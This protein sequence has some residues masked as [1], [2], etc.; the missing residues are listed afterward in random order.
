MAFTLVGVWITLRAAPWRRAV[1]R[2]P[3]EDAGVLTL[4]AI[5]LGFL[6]L[7]LLSRRFVEF[8]APFSALFAGTALA[9]WQPGPA[10]G[11]RG[12][13]PAPVA[14]GA[15]VLAAVGWHNLTQARRIVGD[16]RGMIHRGCAVWIRDHVPAGATVF[17]TDWDEFPQL[18]LH[19]PLQRY[20]VG[21]DPTFM[22]VTDPARWR[23]WRE[24]AE[25]RA[26]SVRREV[27]D[28][29][30]ARHA[31]ADAWYG[32]FMERAEQEPGV[33]VAYADPECRVYEMEPTP[34]PRI[35]APQ[36]VTSWRVEGGGELRVAP[37][38]FVDLSRAEPKPAG[39]CARVDGTLPALPAARARIRLHT[40]DAIQVRVG[41]ALV[42]DTQ[43][44]RPPDYNDLSL[45][46][47]REGEVW[48]F[49]L[50]IA[51]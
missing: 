42:Y 12:W 14:A 3:A 48:G 20:L 50:E 37:G 29:F 39:R 44:P 5:T 51:P 17:T 9:A 27:V 16:D 31:F 7:S 43:A 45:T 6:G 28:T 38:D 13:R 35:P 32:P 23:A 18:F 8:W 2:R 22:Y 25:A 40:D 47:C 1:R 36:A 46:V 10:P 33:R 34:D 11:R 4:G 15:I 24:V 26:G 30:G 19:A 21:L 49:H 41:G